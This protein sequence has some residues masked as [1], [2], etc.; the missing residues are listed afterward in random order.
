MTDTTTTLTIRT[1]GTMDIRMV[2]STTIIRR[3]FTVIPL[4]VGSITVAA[5]S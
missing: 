2:T 4:T 1:T 3:T 5:E